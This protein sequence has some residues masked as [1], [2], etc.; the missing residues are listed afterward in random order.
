MGSDNETATTDQQVSP[1]VRAMLQMMRMSPDVPNELVDQMDNAVAEYEVG[2]NSVVIKPTATKKIAN[3]VLR[4]TL[5]QYDVRVVKGTEQYYARQVDPATNTL[6]DPVFQPMDKEGLVNAITS[7]Y[8]QLTRTVDGAAI[9]KIWNSVDKKVRMSHTI[10]KVDNTII[11]LLPDLFWNTENGDT[12]DELPEGFDCFRRLFDTPKG[13]K[14]VVKYK[15]GDFDELRNALVAAMKIA[16]KEMKDNEDLEEDQDFEFLQTVACHDHERYMDLIRMFA[17]FFMK[18]KPLGTYI[19]EGNGRNGKSSL[20]GL[21][22]TIMGTNNTSKL[23]LG[24][25]GDWHKNHCLINTLVNAPDEEKQGDIMDADLFRTIADHGDIELPVMR[26]QRPIEVSCNFQCV[27]ASNHM[28]SWNGPDAEA[29]IRRAR[30][31]PFEAD[32]SGNDNKSESFE[33]TTYTPER[34]IHFLGTVLGV[35]KYYMHHDFPE[36]NGDKMMKDVLKQNM[37]SYRIYY[38]EFVKYFGTYHRLRDDVFEDYVI[39]CKDHGY[40]IN[41]FEDFR[42]AFNLSRGK[43]T[44]LRGD[45]PISVV[46]RV[47]RG[48][49][50]MHSKWTCPE[51]EMYGDLQHMHEAQ[52]SAVALLENYNAQQKQAWEQ[53][54]VKD[55]E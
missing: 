28:P 2:A 10:D 42:E 45:N 21:I 47:G 55:D 39:W 25:L 17:T 41:K 23:Q 43:K 8:E 30:I 40:D 24:E 4:A 36:S 34:I 12:Y 27:S 19:L 26:G 9:D 20:I 18:N 16:H 6:L 22:H 1:G 52:V 31:I 38:T 51:L 53:L 5:A 14:H 33:Q 48:K 29:C 7:N 3:D 44:Q 46:Y 13:S 15:R 50:C 32:L 54:G 35:A 37:V 49:W 11:Q